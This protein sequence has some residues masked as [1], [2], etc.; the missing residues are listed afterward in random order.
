MHCVKHRHAFTQ[1]GYVHGVLSIVKIM[2]NSVRFGK[3]VDYIYVLKYFYTFTIECTVTLHSNKVHN[4]D[5]NSILTLDKRR[6]IIGAYL[7]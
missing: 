2:F 5:K 6:P 3:A 4:C 1:I 7:S